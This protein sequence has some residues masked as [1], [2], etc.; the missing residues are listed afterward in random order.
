[1][2]VLLLVKLSLLCLEM[3][4]TAG[5]DHFFSL[6]NSELYFLQNQKPLFENPRSTTAIGNNYVSGPPPAFIF[7]NMTI[8]E[9]LRKSM[10]N[11]CTSQIFEKDRFQNYTLGYNKYA[12]FKCYVTWFAFYRWW[13]SAKMGK[14]VADPGG[15]QGFHGNPLLKLIWILGS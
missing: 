13:K 3:L 14:T 15:F 10:V 1:M 5:C 8:W 12:K 9:L 2:W 6:T 4:I 11:A 7:E